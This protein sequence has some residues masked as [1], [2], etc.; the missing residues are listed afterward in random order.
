SGLRSEPSTEFHHSELGFQLA[1]SAAARV[2]GKNWHQLFTAYVAA[3]LGLRNTA[4]GRMRP[5]GAEAGHTAPPWVASG[6]LST[7]KDYT[8]F[9]AM[10][11]NQGV[12]GGRRVLSAKAVADMLADSDRSGRLR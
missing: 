12:S 6:A 4:F 11:A 9:V 10:L 5:A 7:L 2:T 3:P 1:A 8:T